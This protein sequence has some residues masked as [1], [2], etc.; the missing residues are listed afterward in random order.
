MYKLNI[1]K[2]LA[3]VVLMAAWLW[4]GACSGSSA[5]DNTPPPGGNVNGS[6]GGVTGTI[7]DKE[8]YPLGGFDTTIR[9]YNQAGIN[10]A[11]TFNPP[12]SGPEA[13]KFSIQSLPLNQ[14]L[15]FEAEHLN[16]SIGRNLG[17]AQELFFSTPGV[18]DLGNVKLDNPW[19]QLG[20]DSYK[21]KDFQQALYYFNRSLTSRELSATSD[22]FTLSSSAYN[23]M[24]WV[25]V[26]RGKDNHATNPMFPGFEWDEGLGE[27]DKAVINFKDADA[28]VGK[29]G[30]LMTMV[31]DVNADPVQIGPNLPVYGYVKSLF[32]D[33]YTC[34]EKALAANSN[35][36]CEH[37]LIRADDI[38]VA[39]L[40]ITWLTGGA[41]TLNEIEN[42]SKS[43]DI[44]E[45]S[46]Q[47]LSVLPDLM[48]Y[49]PYPQR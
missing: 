10:V 33:A 48:L 4:A 19:L 34:L 27:F 5:V 36:V 47:V 22:E 6:S 2:L 44:N 23:G 35:Y 8:G 39:Q 12:A 3:L 46:M 14:V 16:Q 25:H 45:A 21:Q 20:W 13:G 7:V 29:G 43:T 32:P 11:P 1:Y 49:Q 9:V 28:W 24:A 41:V 31:A 17:Y 40:F 15:T 30:T 38:R 26:K 37:D 18:I 42:F